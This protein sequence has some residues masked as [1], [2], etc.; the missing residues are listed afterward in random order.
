MK[1]AELLLLKLYSYN[2]K[3][4]FY[5]YDDNSVKVFSCPFLCSI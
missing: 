2:L 4:D 1:M 3:V 5:L